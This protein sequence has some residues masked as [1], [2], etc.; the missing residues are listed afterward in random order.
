MFWLVAKALPSLYEVA[1]CFGW[2]LGCI[3]FVKTLL[4]SMQLLTFE[5]FLYTAMWLLR[6]YY[7]VVQFLSVL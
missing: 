1:R 5:C 2:L 3:Y 4:C 7:A 6:L